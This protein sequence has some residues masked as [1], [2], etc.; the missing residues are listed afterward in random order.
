L[1]KNI[2]FQKEVNISTQKLSYRVD[3]VIAKQEIVFSKAAAGVVSPGVNVMIL[4]N[5]RRKN[6]IKN[7]LTLIYAE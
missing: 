3:R 7:V 4:N 1:N 5:F 6:G 2:F